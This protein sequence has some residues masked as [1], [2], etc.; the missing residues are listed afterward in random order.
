M[1]GHADVAFLG[2]HQDHKDCSLEARLFQKHWNVVLAVSERL[3]EPRTQ[4]QRDFISEKTWRIPF[5]SFFANSV[6]IEFNTDLHMF[7]GD[8][9]CPFWP[10]WVDLGKEVLCQNLVLM[11]RSP[12]QAPVSMW[13]TVEKGDGEQVL[14]TKN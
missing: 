5:F 6:K 3:E 11:W 12:N 4:H 14:N 1:R 8:D 9:S 7:A 10:S 2:A 13:N